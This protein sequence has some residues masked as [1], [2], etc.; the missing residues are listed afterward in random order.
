MTA[1]ALVVLLALIRP[2]FAPPPPLPGA[3]LPVSTSLATFGA[4]LELLAAEL[5]AEPLSASEPAAVRLIWRASQPLA[6]DLR[7][8]L[9]LVHADGWL[10]AEWSHSPAGGRYS[11][12]RWQ[13]G[14][15]ITDDYLI[16]AQPP[17][18]GIYTVQVGVRPFGGEWLSISPS[19][20]AAPF[21]PL[22]QVVYR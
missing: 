18:P 21:L 3:G 6:D 1:F 12:D 19:S 15:A 11:T 8:A 16:T 9:Q 22:G 2:A 4:G 14:E 7:P 10:A 5:P 17:T 20:A 13:P